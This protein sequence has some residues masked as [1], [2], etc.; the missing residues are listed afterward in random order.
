MKKTFYSHII[1]TDSLL[2]ALNDLELEEKEREHIVLLIES[3][4]HHAIV[5]AILSELSEEDKKIF[6][7]HVSCDDHEKVWNHLMD[8][9]DHI[10]DKIKQAAES[11]TKELHRDI[12]ET[13]EE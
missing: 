11:I 13:K 2:V 1:E 3:T 5:D 9:V 6:L 12:E 7:E 8:K 4:L 10:E